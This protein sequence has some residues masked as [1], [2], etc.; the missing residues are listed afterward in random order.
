MDLARDLQPYL[1][2][3]ARRFGPELDRAALADVNRDLFPRDEFRVRAAG[4]SASHAR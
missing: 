3:P 2:T 1:D 4:P